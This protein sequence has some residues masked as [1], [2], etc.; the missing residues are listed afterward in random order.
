MNCCDYDCNQGRNCPARKSK[1][2]TPV[3]WSQALESVWAEPDEATPPAA[4]PAPVQEPVGRTDQ[5]IVDQTEELAVWLLS[6]GFN[7][8][9]ATEVPMRENINPIAERCWAAACH[10]Q[11]MLTASDPENAV[12]ELDVDATPPAQAEQEPVAHCEAGPE[13]CPVCW[14]E[15]RS[16][17]LAAAVGY[18]QRNTP[19]LVWTEICNALTTTPPAQP[20]LGDIRA[21]KHR[22]HEL[23]GDVLGYK[24]MLD[25]AEEKLKPANPADTNCPYCRNLGYDASGY[26]CTCG[27][28]PHH[29]TNRRPSWLKSF[30]STVLSLLTST[31]KTV[32]SLVSR[33]RKSS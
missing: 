10:I 3:P 32:M 31:K 14:A 15:T 23:E 13:F 5:Q 2:E 11:E 24:Q 4:Q 17:A 28:P 29:S 33:K 30:S 27:L 22:I 9:P 12:A 8:K 21:L 19:P 16:L 18:I 20:A 25:L 1:Y 26:P 7:R 6:W